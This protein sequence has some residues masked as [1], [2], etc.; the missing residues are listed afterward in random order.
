MST[1]LEEYNHAPECEGTIVYKPDWY[2]L[3]MPKTFHAT[4]LPLLDATGDPFTPSDWPHIS[5]MKDEAPSR[6]KGDW[7]AAFVGEQ[8]TV[9]YNPV[10]RAENGLHFWIDCYSSRLCEMREYFGLV[11]LKRQ[12]GTY[13]V[14]FH[15]T[16]GK[17][18][19][20]I[21]ARLRPQLRLCP[22][23]HIDVETGMQHL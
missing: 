9:K 7:G 1:R 6:N 22:Q 18:T 12:D 3:K 15:M 20:P 13:L 17:R 16:L 11:T 10:I 14:N 2:L 8:V 21:E 23:S 5:V 19:Q 4:L